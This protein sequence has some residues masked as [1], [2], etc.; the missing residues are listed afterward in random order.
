MIRA[1]EEGR[2]QGFE[3]L[4][5]EATIPGPEQGQQMAGHVLIIIIIIIVVVVVVLGWLGRK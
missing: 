1:A 3:A 2:S 5:A 4:L